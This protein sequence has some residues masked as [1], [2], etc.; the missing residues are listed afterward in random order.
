MPGGIWTPLQRHW[1]AEKRA[2]AEQQ[3]RRA[4]QAGAF[5]MKTPEQGAATSVFL[6]ASPQ[7][8]GIGGRYFEDCNEAEVVDQLQGIHGV[9]RHA[10]DPDD[11]RRLWD[12]SERLVTA[13]R[14]AAPAAV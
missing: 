11:A 2:A 4:E 5:R 1:S 13:A 10:L 3:A 9:M 8:A 7:V 12:V 14:S 6:A